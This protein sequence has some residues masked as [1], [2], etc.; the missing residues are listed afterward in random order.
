MESETHVKYEPKHSIAQ[1]DAM[2][3]AIADECKANLL[4]LIST[5]PNSPR[6]LEDTTYIISEFVDGM[7]ECSALEVSILVQRAIGDPK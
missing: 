5:D 4:N 6:L 7:M 1:L 2:K 3:N